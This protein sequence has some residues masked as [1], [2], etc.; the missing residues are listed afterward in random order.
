M[1]EF[2][3]NSAHG[4]GLLNEFQAT[5]LRISCEYI[6]KL[7]KEIEQILHAAESKAA[8]P[9][10]IPDVVPGQRRMVEDYIARVRAQ[11]IRVLDGQGIS[12]EKPSIPAT[13]AIHVALGAIDIAIEELRPNY[14]RGYGEV[15]ELAAVELD[16]IVGELRGLIS[17]IDHY[18]AQGVGGDLKARL[19]RLDSRDN[20]VQMLLRVEQVVADRGMVEF[21][22]PIASILDRIDDKAFE[23]AVFGRVSSGKSSLLNAILDTDILPIG[24]TPVTAVPTRVA[25]GDKPSMR[26]TFAE[27]PSKIFEVFALREFATEQF[28]PGNTKRVARI[29]VTLPAP[30]LRDGVAFVDTPGLGSLAA[31]GATE[32]LAY[33]PKCDL[34]I[35]L[36]DAG[37]TLSAEDLRTVL[38]LREASIPVNVLLSKA[39]L[40]GAEDCEKALRYTKEH[41]SSEC[42]IE[43]PV[44]PVS[45]IPTHRNLLD[46]WFA[47]SILPLYTNSQELR[48]KSL[49]RKI[50]SL[51]DSVL[52]SLKV[53]LRSSKP[54]TTT[55]QMRSIEARLRR[56]TGLIEEA[57]SIW[58]ARLER[59]GS[60]A[61]AILREVAI[62]LVDEWLK[63]ETTL[64]S[65]DKFVQEPIAGVIH[66]EVGKLHETLKAL[67]VQLRDDLRT[68][69]EELWISDKPGDNEFQWT[70][71][72][73][74]VFEGGSL[75]L[76]VHR[77][78][79]FRLFGR[80]AA[81]A[82]LANMLKRKLGEN[83][84]NS[85]WI[86]AGA[87]EEWTRM[88]ATQLRRRF[89]S[90]AEAF[91][92]HAE[93]TLNAKSLTVEEARSV[94][95][96]IAFLEVEGLDVDLEI[97]SECGEDAS[98]LARHV[99]RGISD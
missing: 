5:R 55:D 91:R 18:L 15:Q 2:K 84:R 79:L 41:I 10:Y 76:R 13:R 9:R 46:R 26:V 61:P 23:I 68:T 64:T 78:V 22:T 95:E 57:A 70:V 3:S 83:L 89:E 54:A 14:M 44:L 58:E 80:R 90:Y 38:M 53:E 34:G 8:F 50:G 82:R 93:R 7:L 25:Y 52:A 17:K 97:G 16:G 36:I 98:R 85:I 6:D 65:A 37:S 1:S 67:A 21:R 43:L 74:P 71:R 40:L 11:L 86:Y 39:D 56:A 51:R 73:T 69:A 77:P 99:Q 87:L 88:V 35:A 66:E 63:E 12:T 19:H 49:N 81:E 29:N 33:L 62:R 96:S 4:E 42:G 75:A 60:E 45:V 92:A 24:V 48:T 94:Q 30:R 27:A 20:D 32:T 47:E 72:G 59:M 31:S 28:N